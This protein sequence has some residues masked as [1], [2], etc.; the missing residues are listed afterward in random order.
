MR[1]RIA[2]LAIL[3][4]A[5][6][7]CGLPFSS[8]P[9]PPGIEN[10]FEF[11]TQTAQAAGIST[12]P[13]VELPPTVTPTPFYKPTGKIA[14]T[15]QVFKVQS[16]DQICLMNADGS[17]YRRLTTED[18][19]RHFYPSMAPDGQSVVYSAFREENIFEIY[20]V[21]LDGLATRLTNR[22]G[23]LTAPEISP[24]GTLV[25]FTYWAITNQ[26]HAV[27]VMN[28]DGS[29]PH[30]VAPSGWDPTWSP[31][32]SQ[33]LFASDMNGNV[34]I[35][36]VNLD[37]SGLTAVTT[38]MRG[39]RGRTDWSA[40]GDWIGTYAGGSWNW[41]VY[42]LRPDGSEIHQISPSGS[43]SLAPSFSPDGQWV[44]FTGYMDNPGEDHGCEIY[45]MRL[46][47]SDIRRLT[48]NDY[49]D[50]QPRWGP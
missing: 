8:T 28:R 7:A 6:L 1:P 4:L 48:D 37:G 30:Q 23:V 45:I 22:L 10:I 40:T 35:Y 16:G 42:L 34:Q 41:E 50:W 33:I 47:G 21:T 2:F 20:E 24:D 14:F 38:S 36:R 17:G 43:V 9:R 31:D 25:T 13:P 39:I 18:G 49:C 44:A 19:I 27:W 5:A 32:G 12:S 15:C 46:D 26:K 29:N 11:A 3:F